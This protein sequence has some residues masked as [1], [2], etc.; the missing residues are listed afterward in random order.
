[1]SGGAWEY[2]FGFMKNESGSLDSA[3]SGFTN[4]PEDK[5]YDSYNYSTSNQDY[6]KGYLGDGTKEFGPFYSFTYNTTP[7]QISGW[8]ADD[9]FFLSQGND[10]FIRG[11]DAPSG[12]DTG[13]AAFSYT[14]GKEHEFTTFR[15]ILTP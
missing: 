5:Y 4:F 12:T 13:I 1:M 15:I 3:S 11:G 10:W 9:A 7:R 8:N 2:V 14:D 6:T